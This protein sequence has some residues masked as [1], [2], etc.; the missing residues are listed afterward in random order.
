MTAK[1][2]WNDLKHADKLRL[3]RDTAVDQIVAD[4]RFGDLD[5]STFRAR[6]A[7]RWFL[8]LPTR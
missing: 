2:D 1:P 4:Y 8:G 5:D 7:R 6:I 3:L